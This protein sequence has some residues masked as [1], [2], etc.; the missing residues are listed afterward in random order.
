MKKI[1]K[2]LALVIFGLPF[3][4]IGVLYADHIE[5]M[6]TERVRQMAGKGWTGDENY[7]M[8]NWAREDRALVWTA[9]TQIRDDVA[10]AIK[11]WTDAI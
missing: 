1:A 9:D 5:Y 4:I 2:A 7:I 3:F 6:A 10:L 11:S 8:W